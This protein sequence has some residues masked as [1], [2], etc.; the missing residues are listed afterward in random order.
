MIHTFYFG[1]EPIRAVYVNTVL[2]FFAVDVA[3]AL[4]YVNTRD[5][6]RQQVKDKYKT[7]SRELR[8]L[9]NVD[10]KTILIKLP[11]LIQLV[12]N[13]T[14]PDA[15]KFQ[16]WVLEDVLPTVMTTGRYGI[17]RSARVPK[18]S[19]YSRE[20]IFAIQNSGML[21]GKAF[22]AIYDAQGIKEELRKGLKH[23]PDPWGFGGGYYVDENN[24]RVYLYQR[25]WDNEV[26]DNQ[27]L[28][29]Q[30]VAA[31]AIYGYGTKQYIEYVGGLL[32]KA[33]TS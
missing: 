12:M 14:L 29:G 17:E 2:W 22:N 32:K 5:A 18:G 23:K 31:G 11:G 9:E 27:Y 24:Q 28:Q 19:V 8:L 25:M 3:K 21:A 13:S 1:K 30:I 7:S 33:I 10:S 26:K 16:E 15:E 20:S 4:G 6:V